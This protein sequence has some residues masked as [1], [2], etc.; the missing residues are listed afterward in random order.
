MRC[1][2]ASQWKTRRKI[3]DD[4]T[5]AKLLELSIVSSGQWPS[6]VEKPVPEVQ[7]LRK[8]SYSISYDV[9]FIFEH[10]W[11][12]AVIDSDGNKIIPK[13]CTGI[14]LPDTCKMKG[15]PVGRPRG[16]TIVSQRVDGDEGLDETGEDGNNATP[17]PG[18]PRGRRASGTVQTP[19]AAPVAPS[20][21]GRK[22]RRDDD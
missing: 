13:C 15:Q 7:V 20:K 9:S 21:D 4:E 18:R 6:V 3:L 14:R 10:L 17:A 16:K 5:D 11:A 1:I 12:K 8:K 2:A 22:R 19:A